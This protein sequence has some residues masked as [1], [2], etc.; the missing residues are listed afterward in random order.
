MTKLPCD[1]IRDFTPISADR[2]RAHG[3]DGRPVIT[4]EVSA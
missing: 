1:S 4:G 2:Q 3:A